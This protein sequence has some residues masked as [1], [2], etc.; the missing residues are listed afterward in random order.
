MTNFTRMSL[1]SL[2]YYILC[3]QY[4]TGACKGYTLGYTHLDNIIRSVLNSLYYHPTPFLNVWFCLGVFG[5][6]KISTYLNIIKD[7]EN[8]E[9]L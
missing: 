1:P 6:D 8:K 5:K 4:A 9:N 2:S 3:L 7:G